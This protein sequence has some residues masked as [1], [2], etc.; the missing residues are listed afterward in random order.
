MICKTF[1]WLL[2]RKG[3]LHNHVKKIDNFFKEIKNKKI[4][5]PFF[6]VVLMPSEDSNKAQVIPCIKLHM[7]AKYEVSQGFG[8]P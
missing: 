8:W 2:M 4:S 6:V 1:L 3:R 7:H 5:P